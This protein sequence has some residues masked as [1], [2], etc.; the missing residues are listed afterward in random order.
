MKYYLYNS[1][2]N[3]GIRPQ[4][5]EGTELVDAVG[6]DYP[7]YFKKLAPE[8]E[9]VLP[10][11]LTNANYDAAFAVLVPII[12]VAGHPSEIVFGR[13]GVNKFVGIV[14][15]KITCVIQSALRNQRIENVGS[16]E[17]KICG[18]KTAH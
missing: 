16:A 8:D 3:N 13:I 5:A 4:V 12:M 1:L 11:A 17:E 2:A 18:M 14:A 7:A 6:I 10:I 15:K 9:V